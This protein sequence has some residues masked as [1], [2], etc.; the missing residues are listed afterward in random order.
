LYPLRIK[1]DFK[2][3]EYL[4][5]AAWDKAQT[6]YISH[7]I[8]PSDQDPAPVQTKVKVLYSSDYLYIGFWAYDPQPSKI[9]AHISDR[10]QIHND[11]HVG[12]ILDPFSSNQHAVELFANPLGI[13]L[14]VKR[15][16]S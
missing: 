9:R 15:V 4:K 8:K 1:R 11:D 5:N 13:Q 6:A 10:D 12:V 7:E 3:N 14:D 16:R 2:I